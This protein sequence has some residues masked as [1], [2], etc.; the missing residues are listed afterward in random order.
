MRLAGIAAALIL[1]PLAAWAQSKPNPYLAQAKV[2]YQGLEYEKCLQRLEQA[3]RWKNTTQ[4]LVDIEIY[5]ALS[6]FNLDQ[7]KDSEAH[8]QLALQLDPKVKLPPFSSPKIE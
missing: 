8:F 6:K 5:S 7:S 3:G 1:L 2:F 4:E